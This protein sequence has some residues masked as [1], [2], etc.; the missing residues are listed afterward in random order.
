MSF[1]DVGY[2]DAYEL[3]FRNDRNWLVCQNSLVG[4]IQENEVHT[5]EE[6]EL[7]LL[8]GSRGERIKA[9]YG[10]TPCS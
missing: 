7:F 4:K 5:F 1:E 8:C 2:D 3:K 10:E 6:K 9:R